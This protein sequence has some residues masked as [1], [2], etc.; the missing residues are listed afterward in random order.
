PV[1]SR[2]GANIPRSVNNI[3]RIKSGSIPSLGDQDEGKMEQLPGGSIGN[4]IP[5][6]PLVTETLLS[7]HLDGSLSQSLRRLALNH[8]VDLGIVIMAGWGG[9]LCRLS[10]QD[11]IVIG[12]HAGSIGRP[13]KD[14]NSDNSTLQLRIDLSGEPNTTQLLE[15]TQKAGLS[16]LTNQ[17]LPLHNTIEAA[18]PPGGESLPPMFQS[19]FQWRSRGLD[20]D[21]LRTPAPLRFDLELQFQE[22]GYGIAG[23]M[24]FSTASFDLGTAERY[25]GYLD[26]MLRSMVREKTRPI[27]AFDILSS[28]E[29]GLILETWNKTREDIPNHHCFHQ[30]FECQVEKDS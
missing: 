16:V 2:S 11:D 26:A 18:N 23:E 30:L 17:E 8:N 22:L 29:K 13:N 19:G 7:I 21:T 4:A 6:Y 25:C 27:A 12:F 20:S 9:V 3:G 28:A 14:K 24:R 1:A 10:S 15:R 5:P